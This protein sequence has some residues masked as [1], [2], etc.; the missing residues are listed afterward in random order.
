[1]DPF[2]TNPASFNHRHD[3]FDPQFIR[4]EAID[5]VGGSSSDSNVPNHDRHPLAAITTAAVVATTAPVTTNSTSVA[6]DATNDTFPISKRRRTIT[7][8]GDE[9]H[10][11]DDTAPASSTTKLL[12]IPST[13][14]FESKPN[15]NGEFILDAFLNQ[16]KKHGWENTLK[17]GELNKFVKNFSQ[18]A[19]KPGFPLGNYK[20]DSHSTLQ[21]KINSALAIV[22]KFLPS[23]SSSD[24][25][26]GETIPAHLKNLIELYSDCLS[27]CLLPPNG[28]TMQA[29]TNLMI[30]RQ[31]MP[32]LPNAVGTMDCSTTRIE[33]QK[34][35][36][37]VI[38]LDD[39]KN[40]KG[41]AKPSRKISILPTMDIMN[42]GHQS[43]MTA[44]NNFQKNKIFIERLRCL[45]DSV[46]SWQKEMLT[47]IKENKMDAV[48]V[49]QN[50]LNKEQLELEKVREK[51]NEMTDMDE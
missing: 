27:T 14:L 29:A 18:T 50:I 22:K 15:P 4:R 38:D 47:A 34:A 1:M 16:C 24:S 36:R 11:D 43:I 30:S 32:S 48:P 26:S 35:G 44:L 31:V 21:K 45:E 8:L 5:F 9:N 12:S 6:T 49:I 25:E 20:A 17:H 42:Q 41:H 37:T 13:L 7:P 40:N 51:L 10:V 3:S 46:N 23:H 28:M 19:F 33:N 2:S 39:Q